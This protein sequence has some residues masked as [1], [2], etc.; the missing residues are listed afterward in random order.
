MA[1]TTNNFQDIWRTPWSKFGNCKE[2]TTTTKV[3]FLLPQ[4]T[5][6]VVYPVHAWCCTINKWWMDPGCVSP[7]LYSSFVVFCT[8]SGR[9]KLKSWESNR[10][11]MHAWIMGLLL[12]VAIWFMFGIFSS[13][14]CYLCIVFSRNAAENIHDIGRDSAQFHPNHRHMTLV[15]W[16][17]GQVSSSAMPCWTHT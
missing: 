16:L 13:R 4:A 14:L 3:V 17:T 9:P 8:F 2:I 5:K 6:I 10:V 7:R 1:R 15:R 11:C 12:A